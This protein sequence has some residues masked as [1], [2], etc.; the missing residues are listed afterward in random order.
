MVVVLVVLAIWLY[1]LR[2][3]YPLPLT[4]PSPLPLPLSSPLLIMFSPS[5]STV[6]AGFTQSGR[7]LSTTHRLT[8]EKGQSKNARVFNT[9]DKTCV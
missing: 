5:G 3:L 9:G 7:G 4:L 1:S 6:F 8:A 2:R